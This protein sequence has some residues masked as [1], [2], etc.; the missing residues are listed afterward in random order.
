MSLHLLHQK[1]MAPCM[2]KIN[3]ASEHAPQQSIAEKCSGHYT[4]FSAMF[5]PLQSI[6]NKV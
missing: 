5:R 2:L 3:L 4:L 1:R 6:T